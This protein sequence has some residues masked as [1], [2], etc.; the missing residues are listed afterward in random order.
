VSFIPNVSVGAPTLVDINGIVGPAGIDPN[1]GGQAVIVSAAVLLQRTAPQFLNRLAT[2]PSQSQETVSG[3]NSPIRVIM[4]RDR[5][6]PQ[7]PTVIDYNGSLVLL[8]V[9]GR[10]NPTVDAIEEFGM[11]DGTAMPAGLTFTHYLGDQADPDPTLVAAFAAK[12]QSYTQVLA[13]ISYTVAVVAPGTQGGF[14][15]FAAT[16]RGIKVRSTEGGT[17]AW[18]D[19][20]AYL[21]AEYI[22]DSTFGMGLDVDWQSVA[23]LD[24]ACETLVGAERKRIGS[25]TIDSPAL[26]DA[27]LQQM[28]DYACCWALREGDVYRLVPDAPV[29]L[30]SC[31]GTGVWGVGVWGPDVWSTGGLPLT[32]ESNCVYGDFQYKPLPSRHGGG[33]HLHRHHGQAVA[34]AE[35]HRLRPRCTRWF[36]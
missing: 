8:L 5:L 15:R 9:W 24:S 25:L 31:W 23:T 22:T 7:I 19:H 18:S 35:G 21:I 33:D 16:I 11:V 28:C 4:G 3:E 2:P 20:W 1:T 27:W 17:R 30:S 6:G 29:S 26:V 32:D 13:G 34:R 10:G 12:G 36:S 14:P